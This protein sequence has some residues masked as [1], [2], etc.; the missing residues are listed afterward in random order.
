VRP[1]DKLLVLTSDFLAT[2]GDDFGAADAVVIDEA[3]PPYREGVA[4]L[5]RK[6]GGARKPEDWLKVTAPRIA[7]FGLDRTEGK[8]V[9]PAP[10]KN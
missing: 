4:A 5:L 3:S 9:C 8:P 10:N 1:A 7:M 6:Q 2:G